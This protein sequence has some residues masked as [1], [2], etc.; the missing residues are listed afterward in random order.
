MPFFDYYSERKKE[1]GERGAIVGR[2]ESGLARYST[3]D[4]RIERIGAVAI[5][6]ALEYK[7]LSTTDQRT[8]RIGAVAIHQI[9]E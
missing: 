3:T 1:K 9:L 8:K 5:H 2:I 4:Q 6:R 7:I